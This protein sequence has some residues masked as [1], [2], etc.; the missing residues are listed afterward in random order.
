MS[1]AFMLARLTKDC[2][3]KESVADSTL[4]YLH[5]LTAPPRPRPPPTDQ[6]LRA[7]APRAL[8]IP[9]GFSPRPSS[10]SLGKRPEGGRS[11]LP[12]PS[13]RAGGK[14]IVAV[15]LWGHVAQGDSSPKIRPLLYITFDPWL[16]LHLPHPAARESKA[17]GREIPGVIGALLSS[18]W[19]RRFSTRRGL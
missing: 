8:F 3:C 19:Q 16:E 12:T 2:D 17:G 18:P 13:R 5:R 11:P 9:P 10:S 7:D 15:A 4:R 14:E 1:I 6:L